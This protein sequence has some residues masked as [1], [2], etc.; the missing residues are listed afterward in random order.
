LLDEKN[1]GVLKNT[2]N[3]IIVLQNLNIISISADKISKIVNSLKIYSH[4][5][6][7]ENIEKFKISEEIKSIIILYSTR[8]T[9]ELNCCTD[10][11]VEI[12]GYKNKLNQVWL[13][14][15]KNALQAMEFKGKLDI[16]IK[17]QEQY[18]IISFSNNGPKIDDKIKEKIFE[19][20]FTTKKAGEGTGLG[21][22][23]CKEIVL[24]HKGE[25]YF[26]TSDLKTV[27]YVKLPI[28]QENK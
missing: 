21:L 8:H 27:F 11:D 28:V 18:I 25:I 20:F 22:S 9:V 10:D 3:L 2:I 5:D 23:I 1:W 15:I 26:E 16:E 19:P 24:R 14:L 7:E 12:E 17:K 4:T 6:I 13:N